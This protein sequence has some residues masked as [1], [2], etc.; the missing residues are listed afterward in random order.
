MLGLFTEDMFITISF[1]ELDSLFNEALLPMMM[2]M[3]RCFPSLLSLSLSLS[4]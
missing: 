2:M 1:S 3:S 4:L